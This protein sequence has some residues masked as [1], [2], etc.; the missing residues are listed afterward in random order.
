MRRRGAG[1]ARTTT[2]LIVGTAAVLGGIGWLAWDGGRAGEPSGPSTATRAAEARAADAPATGAPSRTGRG[3]DGPLQ[4][5]PLGSGATGAAAERSTAPPPEDLRLSTGPST[6]DARR[7]E[8]TGSLRGTLSAVGGGDPPERWRLVLEPSRLLAGREHAEARVVEAEGASFRVDD[9]PFGGYDLRPEATGWNGAVFPVMLEA[10]NASPFVQLV[11]GR[12]G[13]IEGRLVD[14]EGRPVEGVGVVLER[15]PEGPRRETASDALGLFRF[16]DLTD[17]TYG[18]SVGSTDFPLVPP[19]TLSFRPPGMHLSP[20][21]LP[22][23][24]SLLVRVEDDA[25]RPIVGAVVHVRGPGMHAMDGTTD[26]L[27]LLLVRNLRPG[28]CLLEALADGRTS[29]EIEVDPESRDEV[30]LVVR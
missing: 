29:Q 28:P 17:G 23:L 12:A 30:V 5:E 1:A 15:R 14:R 7:F 21:E 9:L 25:G 19:R 20:I 6:T 13:E 16:E 10:G 8:G 22:E 11:I 3:R 2:A 27:G 24:Q 18:L 4:P 26:H